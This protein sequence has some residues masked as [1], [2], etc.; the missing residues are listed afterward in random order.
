MRTS[1]IVFTWKSLYQVAIVT[2]DTEYPIFIAAED[3][4]AVAD[5]VARYYPE[6]ESHYIQQEVGR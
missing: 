3:P 6:A 1:S 2:K 5:H 4:K